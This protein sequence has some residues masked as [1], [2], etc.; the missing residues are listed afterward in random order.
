MELAEGS[1]LFDR[2]YRIVYKGYY[3]EKS[4]VYIVK[5]ILNT[6]KYLHQQGI[7]HR[8]LKKINFFRTTLNI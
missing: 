1:K 4:T 3:S 6:V 7:A 2:S 5:Q 8:D